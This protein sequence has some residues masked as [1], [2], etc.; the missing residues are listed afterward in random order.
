MV[1][2]G[3]LL[4]RQAVAS[5][6]VRPRLILGA[7]EILERLSAVAAAGLRALDFCKAGQ[8]DRRGTVSADFQ[9]GAPA[10]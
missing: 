4:P 5:T 10:I 1:F 9:G 3:A 7:P 6:E 2:S 8:R